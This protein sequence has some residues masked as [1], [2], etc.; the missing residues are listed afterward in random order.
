MSNS[1]FD[2]EQQLLECWG[3]IDDINLVTSHFTDDPMWEGM[4]P[5]VQDALSNK[6]IAISELYG[7]K[8]DALWHTFEQVCK[9]Y[10]SKEAGL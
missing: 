5:K 8:F 7:L 10:H 6:Y 3:V 4:D 1:I 9:E 2:L